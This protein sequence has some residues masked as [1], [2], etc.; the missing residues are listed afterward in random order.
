VELLAGHA[1]LPF[2]QGYAKDL[3]TIFI[4]SAVDLKPATAGS[5][6]LSVMVHRASGKKCERCWVYRESVGR[7]A[8]HPTVCEPCVAVL[9]TP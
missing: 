5:P 8:E 6:E 3:A 4:V 1:L 9:T 7:S 2:L